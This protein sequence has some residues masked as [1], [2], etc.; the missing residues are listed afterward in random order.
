MW[1]RRV[2]DERRAGR[3]LAG[4]GRA[5][6][7]GC[8]LRGAVLK[9]F[10]EIRD[11]DYEQFLPG[12]PDDGGAESRAAP[13]ADRSKSD[14]AITSTHTF[15]GYPIASIEVGDVFLDDREKPTV[16]YRLTL[17]DGS[18]LAGDLVF[19]YVDRDGGWYP[20]DSIEWLLGGEAP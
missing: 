16:P 9:L 13:A 12:E 10:E 11:A 8:E 15:T 3:G 14:A 18:V 17:T 20:V 4:P 1:A 5:T 2:L 6:A 7:P 19:E